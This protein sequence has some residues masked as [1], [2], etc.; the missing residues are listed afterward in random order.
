M[1][2]LQDRQKIYKRFIIQG[3]L[4]IRDKIAIKRKYLTLK[5]GYLIKILKTYLNNYLAIKYTLNTQI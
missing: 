3:Y 2:F 4:L 1:R 5:Y